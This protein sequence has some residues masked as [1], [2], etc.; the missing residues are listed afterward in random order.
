MHSKVG[1]CNL[2][3]AA[4]AGACLLK[5]KGNIL[6]FAKTM[7]NTVLFLLLQFAC[8]IQKCNYLF[9]REIKQLYVEKQ[10]ILTE[11]FVICTGN[12]TTQVKAMADEVEYKMQL[13]G[14]EPLHVEGAQGGSWI[15]IDYGAVIVHIFNK[16]AREFYKLDK[17]WSDA[18]ETDISGLV[19]TR[20]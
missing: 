6:A 17:L 14:L 3:G 18:S 1:S 12:S 11:Y 9:A 15:L 13:G 10:T 16:E 7:G 8:Q 4:S 19:D 2:K 20:E 5:N